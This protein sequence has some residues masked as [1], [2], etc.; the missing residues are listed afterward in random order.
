M[1]DPYPLT[2]GIAQQ[3][4][5]LTPDAHHKE[6][7]RCK[8]STV[9][10][11]NAGVLRCRCLARA[12]KLQLPHIEAYARLV[13]AKF[14]LQHNTAIAGPI[15]MEEEHY[16]A[17]MSNCCSVARWLLCKYVS[18]VAASSG[19]IQPQRHGSSV[20]SPELHVFNLS[21]WFLVFTVD[22]YQRASQGITRKTAA[23]KRHA[24]G[25]GSAATAVSRAWQDTAH[26]HLAAS[27]AAAVP[28][29]AMPAPV[30]T[31]GANPPR[32]VLADLYLHMEHAAFDPDFKGLYGHLER[33]ADQDEHMAP[34]C[35]SEARLS[36]LCW[37]YRNNS[38]VVP[39]ALQASWK[40]QCLPVTVL[41]PTN[42]NMTVTA[43]FAGY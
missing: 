8:Y 27:L 32:H 38:A 7:S 28:V 19:D 26:C 20:A 42:F 35:L 5:S 2:R 11:L 41:S 14:S 9:S 31:A 6:Q 30:P 15:S 39:Q 43:H 40:V 25:H 23:Q 33:H 4:L 34:V 22:V 36:S 1:V 24:A 18:C 12:Q 37:V 3:G 10:P 29:P 17:G 16:E 21:C 13:L